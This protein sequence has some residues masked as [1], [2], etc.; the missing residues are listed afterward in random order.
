MS[1]KSCEGKTLL[2]PRQ[3]SAVFAKLSESVIPKCELDF[4][5]SLDL[6]VAVVLSAQATDKSVNRVT[7]A[8]WAKCRT[9]Q[10]YLALGEDGVA[11]SIRAIG[12]YRNKAKSI[13]GLCKK[14]LESFDGVV[15][16]T[17]EELMTLPGVG[18]K[19]ANVVLN[20]WFKQPT[21]PVDTHVFRVANR[22][23]LADATTPDAVEQA[24]MERV[25]RKHQLNAHHY[26]LLH[27]R[28]V[29]TALHPKCT[30]CVVAKW[31]VAH[32]KGEC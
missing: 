21:I 31:C 27:G 29:C 5:T 22:M 20:V 16:S 9:P 10:D 7:P 26:L 30:E 3:V 32:K 12:L 17:R 11:D 2:G 23:G 8:L 18:R 4:T 13:I 24:L 28:Y 25:P 1:E 15:P 19:T 6:L 14:L